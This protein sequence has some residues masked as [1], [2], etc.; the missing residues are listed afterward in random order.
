LQEI[1]QPKQTRPCTIAQEEDTTTPS[2]PYRTQPGD[3]SITHKNVNLLQRHPS[4]ASMIEQQNPE[5]HARPYLPLLNLQY[6]Q[7]GNQRTPD[8]RLH[9][10]FTPHYDP[11]SLSATCYVEPYRIHKVSDQVADIAA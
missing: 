5:P 11:P 4:K 1:D 9:Y 7:P 10:S 3:D 2:K 6:A 8:P